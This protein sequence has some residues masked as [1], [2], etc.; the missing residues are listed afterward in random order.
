MLNKLNVGDEVLIFDNVRTVKKNIEPFVRGKVFEIYKSDDL[1]YH[2]SPWYV[3]LYKVRGEDGYTYS[4]SYNYSSLGTSYFLTE[5]DY[6]K[7][8]YNKINANHELI[9][10]LN[11]SNEEM[12]DL[13]N[14]L[15]YE[16]NVKKRTLER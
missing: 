5:E 16:K 3:E 7:F 1:S 12:L 4:G 11:E 15:N 2:G 8:L 6:I 14:S 13:I 9:K 10:T